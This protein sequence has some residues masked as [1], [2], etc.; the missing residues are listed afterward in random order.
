MIHSPGSASP[1]NRTSNTFQPNLAR[2]IA[3]E[4]ERGFRLPFMN[5]RTQAKI[6]AEI[7]I[8][9]ISR[10]ISVAQ[11]CQLDSRL[12]LAIEA[13]LSHEFQEGDAAE[14]AEG[15]DLDVA[16]EAD[17]YELDH[18]RTHD[19]AKPAPWQIGGET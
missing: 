4:L 6:S 18:H 19:A 9:M 14:A 7:V 8:E 2:I 1:A 11:D 5:L 16:G 17:A 3:K 13:H 15:S 12:L 10:H